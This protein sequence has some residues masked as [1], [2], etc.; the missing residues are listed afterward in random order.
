MVGPDIHRLFMSMHV[1]LAVLVYLLSVV[2][3]AEDSELLFYY[4]EDVFVSLHGIKGG[5]EYINK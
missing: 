1:V 2:Y 5:N 4:N 3:Q